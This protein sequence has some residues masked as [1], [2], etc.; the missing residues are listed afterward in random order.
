MYAGWKVLGREGREYS[1]AID[2]DPFPRVRRVQIWLAIDCETMRPVGEELKTPDGVGADS[3]Q[4]SAQHKRVA[5]TCGVC[6][7]PFALMQHFI[8][9]LSDEW[10]GSPPNTPLTTAKNRNANM[11]R[12][13]TYPNY[14]SRAST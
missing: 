11:M 3:E 6:S 13:A 2:R 7:V 14:S 5:L 9:W 10:S 1:S 12:L 8:I 4:F